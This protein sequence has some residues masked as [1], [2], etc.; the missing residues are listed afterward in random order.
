[1]K[2]IAET[3]RE[4]VDDGKVK[5][6]TSSIVFPELE[7]LLSFQKK[8]I[9]PKGRNPIIYEDGLERVFIF[10]SGTAQ[11]LN[12]ERKKRLLKSETILVIP[13]GMPASFLTSGDSSDLEYIELAFSVER[14]HLR[15][16]SNISFYSR[17]AQVNI[18][19]S[20]K[21]VNDSFSKQSYWINLL[22]F[23]AEKEFNYKKN[24][25]DN[26][27]FVY[28]VTGEVNM[29]GLILN[30]NDAALFTWEDGTVLGLF[31]KKTELLILEI[32]VNET[33]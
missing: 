21:R 19:A 30:Y 13:Q 5:I 2:F 3:S 7:G 6:Y 31:M 23:N 11:I 10:L 16:K 12:A 29:N 33:K 20:L 17:A 8:I 32:A 27:L 4:F 28:V 25:P 14:S 18:M 24:N 22:T 15:Q 26:N 9:L 1:M